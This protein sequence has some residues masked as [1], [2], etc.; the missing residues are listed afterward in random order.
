MDNDRLHTAVNDF[1]LA[2]S[3]A[4]D[5]QGTGIGEVGVYLETVIVQALRT[6]P[7]PQRYI[8]YETIMHRVAERILLPDNRGLPISS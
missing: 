6:I 1:L 5:E 2:I 8:L 3:Y 7:R 4:I